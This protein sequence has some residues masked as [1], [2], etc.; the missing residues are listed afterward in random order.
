MQHIDPVRELRDVEDPMFR[1]C[2][3]ANLLDALAYG[4]HWPPVVR[5]KPLLNSAQLKPGGAPRVQR[6]SPNAPCGRLDG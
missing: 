3:D 2:V 6:K 1:P 4:G 5:V